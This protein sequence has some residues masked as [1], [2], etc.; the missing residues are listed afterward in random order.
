M[1]CSA[2]MH[3][4]GVEWNKLHADLLKQADDMR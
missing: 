1:K 2:K 4:Q 3:K